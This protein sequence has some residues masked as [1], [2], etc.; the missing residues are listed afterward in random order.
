M[1]KTYL[2]TVKEK[3]AAR[4]EPNGGAKKGYTQNVAALRR[5]IDE[6]EKKDVAITP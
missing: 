2:D 3:L 4:I 6:L 1:R 5:V